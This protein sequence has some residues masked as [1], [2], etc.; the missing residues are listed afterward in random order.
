MN[1]LS[2]ATQEWSQFR[3]EV[4]GRPTTPP[5]PFQC[6]WGSA[7]LLQNITFPLRAFWTLVSGTTIL[8]SPS[9]SARKKKMDTKKLICWKAT[10]GPDGR[11][12]C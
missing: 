4:R 12:F 9:R 5:T 2:F 6:I 8:A 10:T 7:G 1:G 3:Y 11:G